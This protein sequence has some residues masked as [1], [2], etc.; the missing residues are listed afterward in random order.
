LVVLQEYNTTHG[1]MNIKKKVWYIQCNIVNLCGI[2]FTFMLIFV[3]SL[4]I[5]NSD[6]VPNFETIKCLI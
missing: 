5:I 6:T 4:K 1:P 2:P 3:N